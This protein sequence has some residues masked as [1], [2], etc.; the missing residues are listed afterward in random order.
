MLQTNRGCQMKNL[1][2]K[3][4]QAAQYAAQ[5]FFQGSGGVAFLA[6]HGIPGHVLLFMHCLLAN[7]AGDLGSQHRVIDL[8]PVVAHRLNEE[9]FP[10]RKY[11]GHGQPERAEKRIVGIK[12]LFRG[13]CIEVE[14]QMSLL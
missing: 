6:C 13:G 4:L 1:R 2:C 5:N 10:R 12:I 9:I 14:I 8:V 7:K 11:R 3:A